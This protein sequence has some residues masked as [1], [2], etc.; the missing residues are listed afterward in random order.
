MNRTARRA[1]T[2]REWEDRMTD[3]N[4]LALIAVAGL[5]MV[6]SA[7]LLVRTLIVAFRKAP[8]S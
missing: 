6:T 8:A 7:A 4:G 3:T 1:A 2:D 5:G